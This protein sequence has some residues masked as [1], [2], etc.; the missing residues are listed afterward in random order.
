MKAL[1]VQIDLHLTFST[2]CNI[3]ISRLCY[4]VSVHLSVTK[5]HWVAVHARNTAAAPASEVKG[6][7]RSPTN[8]AAADVAAIEGMGHLALC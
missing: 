2:R 3:Y 7:I 4:D 6:I 8:M 1:W 5:V